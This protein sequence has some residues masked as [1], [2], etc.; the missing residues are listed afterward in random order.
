[1]QLSATL[2]LSGSE[3]DMAKEDEEKLSIDDQLKLAQINKWEHEK[4]DADRHFKLKKRTTRQ[5]LLFKARTLG[6]TF[7]TVLTAGVFKLVEYFNL[8]KG[9]G[10]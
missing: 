3:V 8:F 5:S 9:A 4:K 7:V 2:A 6:F 1:M 10:E